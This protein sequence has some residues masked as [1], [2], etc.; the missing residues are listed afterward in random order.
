M[1]TAA[2]PQMTWIENGN[3]EPEGWHVW[4]GLRRYSVDRSVRG[5]WLVGLRAPMLDNPFTL[6][7]RGTDRA[8]RFATSTDAAAAIR[9]IIDGDTPHWKEH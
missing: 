6:A 1:T 7:E 4:V 2:P 5:D 9:G 3:G 8:L